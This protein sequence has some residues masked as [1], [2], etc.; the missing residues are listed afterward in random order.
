MRA[1]P[2]GELGQEQPQRLLVADEIVVDEVEMASIAHPV[3]RIELDQDLRV[4]FG[5]RNASVELDDVAEL[6]GKR[7]AAGIL[8]AEIEV[9]LE[10]EQVETRHRRLGDVGLEFRRG[11][12]A[13][14]RAAVPSRNEF[15]DD[16]LGLTEHPEIRACINMW[17]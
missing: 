9:V 10:F 1:L 14:P 13:G 5:P 7:T 12:D 2:F 8:H 17:A 11:E 16:A 4:R 3:E 6:A 15:V